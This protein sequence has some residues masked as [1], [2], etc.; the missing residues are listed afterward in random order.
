LSQWTTVKHKKNCR[1]P[2]K[3]GLPSQHNSNNGL[4][5]GRCLGGSQTQSFP[6]AGDFMTQTAEALTP[7]EQDRA[8]GRLE[9]GLPDARAALEKRSKT[10]SGSPPRSQTIRRAPDSTRVQI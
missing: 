8:A 4:L 10:S 5:V 3:M 7:A 6:D 1:N 2:A 9:A